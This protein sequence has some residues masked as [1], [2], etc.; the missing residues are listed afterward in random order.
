MPRWNSC[1]VFQVDHGARH[2]WQFSNK[3]AIQKEEA[4]LANEALSTKPFEKDWQTLFQPRLN[5]AW[6]PPEKVFLRALQLP[7]ADFAETQSMVDLQLEKISP[8]PVAQVVWSFETL[9]HTGSDM[10]TVIVIVVARQAV[11]EFLGQLEAQEYMADRLELPLIDLLQATEITGDGVW[12][13]PSAAGP[14][15][16]AWWYAGIL[17]HIALLTLPNN[18]GRG[19][20]LQN[21][22]VQIMWA[23]E[24][25]G[26]I[27]GPP[28]FHIVAEGLLADEWRHYVPSDHAV[29]IV[30]PPSP[31]EIATRTARRAAEDKP[32]VP[33]L[34]PEYATRYKQRFVDRLWMRGLGAV[35]LLYIFG[36]LIYFAFV[37]VGNFRLN[38]IED[39]IAQRGTEYTNTV[40]L[41]ER[42]KVLQDQMD[43]QFAA[44]DCYKAIADKLPPELTLNSMTFDKGRKLTLNGTAS[45]D[46]VN[47]IHTFNEEL[48]RV[49]VRDQP[50]FAKVAPPNSN[51]APGN[52]DLA[53]NF[54]CELRRSTA[55]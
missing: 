7:K 15:L 8:L 25:E 16:V 22:L 1:N 27:T 12:I 6:L 17:Q 55:E 21:Q 48:R 5:V 9:P 53:W 33:L 49:T 42:V 50:L 10:Q 3:F 46:S 51:F 35:L 43:L 19:P 2:L 11:E 44:L 47:A 30:E 4:K 29:D 13:Y 52:Q 45:R 18:E 41:K 14:C 39:E 24:L 37:Q 26:W 20:L 31:T 23:G 34:P 36:V 40:R 54:V 28:K 32:R 38:G